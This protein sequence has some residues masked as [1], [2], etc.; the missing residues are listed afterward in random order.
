MSDAVKLGNECEDQ[1]QSGACTTVFV[2]RCDLHTATHVH[3]FD[4]SV[5]CRVHG[6]SLRNRSDDRT[7]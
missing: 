7:M 4:M 6:H 5:L 3:I 2:S 1:S